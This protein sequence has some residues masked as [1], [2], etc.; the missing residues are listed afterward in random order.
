VHCFGGF[1]ITVHGSEVDLRQIKPKAR[2][3]LRLL[4]LNGGNPVHREVLEERLWPDAD[5]E[6][7][8][9]G[10]HVAISA[11]RRALEPD[12][13]RGAP[14]LLTREGNAYRLVLADVEASDLTEFE[15]AAAK[16]RVARQRQDLPALSAAF[17]TL[18]RL[19]TGDLL[20]EDGSSEWVLGRREDCR[21]TL[22]EAAQALSAMLLQ[23]GRPVEAA[24]ACGAGIRVDRYQDSLWRL[25]IAARDAAGEVGAAGRARADYERVL[26]ELGVE[27][28]RA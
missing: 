9:R 25:L 5:P 6:N 18:C 22:V 23:A 19:H 4:A 1:S 24:E 26:A 27:A 14:S 28:S 10:L 16:A 13:P 15:E 8:A 20:P 7:A 12:V 11:V 21:S 3:L 2:A 17:V